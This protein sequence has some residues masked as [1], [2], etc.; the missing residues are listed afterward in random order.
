MTD[1]YNS[2]SPI[3]PISEEARQKNVSSRRATGR[4]RTSPEKKRSTF[5]DLLP[6]WNIVALVVGLIWAVS[7]TRAGIGVLVTVY[8]PLALAVISAA[9][10]SSGWFSLVVR[11]LNALLA[12]VVAINLLKYIGVGIFTGNMF[13]FFSLSVFIPIL[14][15]LFLRPAEKSQS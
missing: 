6:L 7:T 9:W 5:L 13:F 10:I 14:N 12:I 11:G 4:P 1:P 3:A 8:G 15:A 2:G